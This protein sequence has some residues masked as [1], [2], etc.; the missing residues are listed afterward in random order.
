M[1][2]DATTGEDLTRGA[3]LSIVTSGTNTTANSRPASAKRMDMRFI[4]H[5]HSI[6]TCRLMDRRQQHRWRTCK[7]GEPMAGNAQWQIATIALWVAGSPYVAG[8]L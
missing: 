7:V 3:G 1:D 5:L 8:I 2:G 6:G 4:V